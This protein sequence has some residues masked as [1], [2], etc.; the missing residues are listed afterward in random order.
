MA[1]AWLNGLR[2][3]VDISG[4][5]TRKRCAQAIEAMRAQFKVRSPTVEMRFQYAE[6]LVQAGR[7]AEA[8]PVLLGLADEL[9][10]DGFIDRAMEAIQKVLS[11]DPQA[12]VQARLATLSSQ[13]HRRP[14][15]A[16]RHVEEPA[17]PPAPGPAEELPLLEL[18][19]EAAAPPVLTEDGQTIRE[20]ASEALHAHFGETHW[21]PRMR[22]RLAG[23]LR[24]AGNIEG[25]AAILTS[26]ADELT[27]AGHA[28][29]A[30]ALLEQ[31]E[32]IR[33][34][35]EE[36]R[37]APLPSVGRGGRQGARALTPEDS[38]ENW[39]SVLQRERWSAG[40]GSSPAEPA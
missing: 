19:P 5:I 37:L 26:L 7:G 1:L 20:K 39:L 31:V 14:R 2:S 30:L 29:K 36:L 4:L 27:E 8:V 10:A 21:S 11:V 9:M 35:T 34:D 16:G 32:R 15:R 24:R 3:A 38:F 22:L 33:H 13:A 6:L 18:L 17:P 23:L 12:D 40:D 25:A 28:A